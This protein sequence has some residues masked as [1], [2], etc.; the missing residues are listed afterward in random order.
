MFNLSRTF[1]S[2]GRAA[3]FRVKLLCVGLIS[4]SAASSQ[5]S[6]PAFDLDNPALALEAIRQ[7]HDLPGLGA[8]V[9]TTDGLQT[10]AVVGVRKKGETTVVADDDLWHLGSCG[11][12]MTATLIARLV[13]A[14]QLRYEQTLGE[15]FPEL[16]PKMEEPLRSVTLLDLLSH[17]SGLP[18][19][20]N[21]LA[22]RHQADE[23][24]AR[25][26][27]LLDAMQQPLL[28]PP[29]ETYHYSNWGYTLAGHVAEQ[30]TGQSW[31]ALMREHVFEPLD[32]T[33]AGFG[34]IGTPGELDQPWPHTS[35]G[36]PWHSNGPEVDNIP[37]LGPAGRI[38]MSLEDW[39]KFAAEHLRGHRGESDY[40]T[41]DSFRMLHTA[42]GDGYALGWVVVDRPWA[43][44]RALNHVGDNTLNHAN[45]WLAPEKG[46]ALLLTTNQS[47]AHRATDE[48]A[49]GLIIAWLSQNR[50]Q[51][52]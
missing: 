36:A 6:P 12:A 37:A 8:A 23:Q 3:A 35:N 32:M 43:G 7:K 2:S 16:A 50:P 48:V 30:A 19:N 25:R 29:G 14:G 51:N 45:I 17:R 26:K 4:A 13:E 24:S 33:S 49:T 38:H 40:L 42:R 9:V 52:P 21:V 18:A 39:A 44:G 5:P 27:V 46:F 10:L 41:R 15:S 34:G 28:S 22:Y 20:F 11:K 31:E 1:L 47:T